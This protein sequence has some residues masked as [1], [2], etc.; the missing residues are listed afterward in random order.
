[1]ERSRQWS[2]REA[3]IMHPS[4]G[5]FEGRN[6]KADNLAVHGANSRGLTFG[7]DG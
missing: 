4:D 7:D 6:P 3:G 2:R 5:D 1:M